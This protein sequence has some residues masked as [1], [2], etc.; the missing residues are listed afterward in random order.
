M[1]FVSTKFLL[2][3]K[4]FYC[5]LLGDGSGEFMGSSNHSGH[6]CSD[7]KFGAC[8]SCQCTKNISGTSGNLFMYTR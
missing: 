5:F 1:L 3:V 4:L 7:F 2:I 8:E 6:F